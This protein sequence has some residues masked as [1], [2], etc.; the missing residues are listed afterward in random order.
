LPELSSKGCNIV[1]VEIVSSTAFSKS[2]EAN[3]RF[4]LV[5]FEAKELECLDDVRRHLRVADDI[6]A[7][8]GERVKTGP[9]TEATLVN[10][11]HSV[12]SEIKTLTR[13]TVE[14]VTGSSIKYYGSVKDTLNGKAKCTSHRSELQQLSNATLLGF[15]V[16]RSCKIEVT[17][18]RRGESI[19]H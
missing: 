13:S 17:H 11:L 18:N 3:E 9:T 1:P 14:D 5:D 2:R 7:I 15:Y 16:R 4:T 10:I 12:T 8:Y 19:P 6:I